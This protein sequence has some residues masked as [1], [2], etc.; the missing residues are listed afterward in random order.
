MDRFWQGKKITAYVA[1][2]H[3][4]RFITPLMDTL[5]GM[6]ARVNYL[7]AQAERSQE[8]TA[9][10]TGL[11]YNHIFDFLTPEDTPEIQQIYQNQRDKFAA[12]LLKDTAYS[13]QIQTVLDKTI[14]TTAQEYVAFRNFFKTYRP[15]L[16]L[17]LHELNRWGKMFA[18]HAKMAGIPV[19]TLQEGLYTTAS[20]AANFRLTGHVQ[21]STLC[22]VWGEASR[23]KLATFEAPEDRII[24][25]GNTHLYNEIIKLKKNN[26]RNQK[27]QQYNTQKKIVV[28]LLFSGT[29]IKVDEFMPLVETFENNHSAQLFVKFHPATTQLQISQWKE[30]IPKNLAEGITFVHGQEN[31]YDLMAMSDLCVLPGGSTT[32]IEALAMGKPLV[33]LDLNP[34]ITTKTD[35]VKRG[36]AIRM[37]PTELAKAILN[38]VDFSNY[39]KP[40]EIQAYI[41]HEIFKLDGCIEYVNDIFKKVIKASQAD[42]PPMIAK[43]SP[44]PKKDWT[45]ILPAGSDPD[46]FLTILE[47]VSVT[48]SN[49]DF[50]IIVIRP[51]MVDKQTEDILNS[52]KGDCTILTQASNQ[53]TAGMM[54]QAAQNA[55]GTYLV[56]MD[57]NLMPA[58]NWI[59]HLSDGFRHWGEKNLFGAKIIN[60]FDNIVHSGMVVDINHQPVSAYRHLDGLFPPSCNSRPFQMIDH[61]TAMHR[62]LFF[63]VGGF[64][65][66]SGR[67][68]F[69]DLCLR[70]A[71]RH[72]EK[73]GIIFLHDVLLKQLIA[74]PRSQEQDAAI[75]FYSRWHSQLLESEEK[76]LTEDKVTAPELEAARMSRAM[77]TAHYR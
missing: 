65:P 52:L 60:R 30:T 41:N 40:Q 73:D 44:S 5:A 39:L 76:L 55:V 42:T 10:E 22:L 20:A 37:T 11:S 69:M 74:P 23:D 26:I 7:V 28:L 19:I 53:S 15:D 27:R 33:M 6:G 75:F 1:L 16:C 17:A 25:A 49:H 48:C 21:Y 3:H 63:S 67:Y 12:A 54:N 77:E 38:R 62:D 56:F 64:D 9:I 58:E 47:A 72:P 18:F 50:E 43:V 34:S 35:I 51:G 68:M 45:I 57:K 24:P 4:T 70:T 61:F 66:R 36:A 2:K 71:S 32:G 31:T 8:V 13:L 29:I 46:R 59:E 14:S